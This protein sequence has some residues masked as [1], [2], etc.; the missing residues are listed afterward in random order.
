[1]KED[2]DLLYLER[3]IEATEQIEQYIINCDFGSFAKDKKTYDAV[4]MQ[5]EVIGEMIAR[6][7][8]KFKEDHND[9]PWHDAIGMRNQIAHGYF[10]I[11][12]KSVWLTAKEDLPE[13]KSKLEELL[14]E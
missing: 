12:P 1:M 5:I 3:I 10:K 6:L 7:S 2:R 11:Q 13:L 8:E 9:L 14:K 4:L